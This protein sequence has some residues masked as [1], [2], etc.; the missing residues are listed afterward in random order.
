[1]PVNDPFGPSVYVPDLST[2]AQSASQGWATG[3]SSLAK[4]LFPDPNALADARLKGAQTQQLQAAGQARSAIASALTGGDPNRFA[5]P[6]FRNNFIANWAQL[7]A[8]EQNAQR[9]T[10]GTIIAN[11]NM[12][13]ADQDQFLS[14]AGITNYTQTPSGVNAAL[15]NQIKTAQIGAGATIGAAQIG[16]NATTTAA[17]TAASGH[18]IGTQTEVAG[19]QQIADDTPVSVITPTGVQTI[20]AKEMR[21]GGYMQVPPNASQADIAAIITSHELPGQVP[22]KAVTPSHGVSP[23]PAATQ[24]QTSPDAQPSPTPGQALTTSITKTQSPPVP[25][26]DP[27]VTLQ[28]IANQDLPTSTYAADPNTNPQGHYNVGPKM[29]AA[30]IGRAQ[31]LAA[32][33]TS[34]FYLNQAGAMAQAYN[35][36]VGPAKATNK[37]V[38]DTGYSWFPGS[39]NDPPTVD[40]APDYQ[41]PAPAT[42]LRPNPQ[43]A[44]VAPPAATAAPTPLVPSNR[45]AIPVPNPA[46]APAPAPPPRPPKPKPP[47]AKPPAAPAA[48]APPAT[49]PASAQPA[50]AAPAPGA[51]PSLAAI[52]P[53]MRKPG[54]VYHGNIFMGGTPTDPKAWQ[55]ATPAEI[56]NAKQNGLFAQ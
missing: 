26:E 20:T 45:S 30:V 19:R 49:P 39:K 12:S 8:E 27:A 53:A 28:R 3:I 55:V 37:L 51:S 34:Q 46:P 47:T 10:L 29:A 42:P 1:M 33:R 2:G 22:L 52:P 38:F 13:G 54:V 21:D 48:P 17:T 16:A 56:A 31:Q 40:F 9:S 32:D 18:I 14:H 41:L 11:T 5:D 44:A 50:A 43:P 15:A 7:P 25:K 23:P 24:P 6:T 4:G 36:I 35:E